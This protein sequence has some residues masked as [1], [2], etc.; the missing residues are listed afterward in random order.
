MSPCA[1]TSG[2]CAAAVR[3][4]RMRGIR[5]P[6]YW[7]GKQNHLPMDFGPVMFPV[8]PEAC[9]IRY[10]R[11]RL[12][13][14]EGQQKGFLKDVCPAGRTKKRAPVGVRL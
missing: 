5:L 13:A 10:Q 4:G 6:E 12:V 8:E 9:A 11:D 7:L 3:P 1:R 14:N 2:K